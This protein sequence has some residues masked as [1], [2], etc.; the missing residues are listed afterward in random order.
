MRKAPDCRGKHHS[1]DRF[2]EICLLVLLAKG[3]GH[4]YGFIE[5]L[6][7][8]G[9]QSKEFNVGTLYRILR[10][11][12]HDGLVFS[13]WEAGQQGPKKRPYESTNVGREELEEWISVLKARRER[14]DNLISIYREG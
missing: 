6:G 13:T 7:R 10:K 4:G 1:M 11:L 9:F 3:P 12:E 5:Q 2:L 14:I 8:F